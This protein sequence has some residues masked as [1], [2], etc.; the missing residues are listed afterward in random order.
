MPLYVPRPDGPLPEDLIED[1]GA[2]LAARYAA[3]EDELIREVARRA[4]RDLELQARAPGAPAG[5]GL[6]VAER[7]RQNRAL[8]ELAGHRAR[9]LRDLQTRAVQVVEGLRATGLAEQI[10]DIA[11]TEGE[12]AAAERLGMARNLPPTTVLSGTSTS[13]VTQ[14]TMDLSNRLETMNRRILRYPTDAYQRIIATTATNT[15]LGVTT[16]RVQQ[17]QAVAAF[18]SEGVTG[19]VDQAGRRWRIGSYAEMAGRTAVNRAYQEAGIARMQASGINLVTIVV[20]ASACEK[21][22]RWSNRVLSTDGT[23]GPIILPHATENRGVEVQVDGTLSDARASGWGHPNDRCQVVAYLPGL[24]IPADSTTYNPDAEK[25]RA[26]MRTLERRVRAAKRAEAVSGDDI[27][28]TDA[29]RRVRAAQ[30]EIRA[31]A[32]ATGEARSNYREQLHFTD[33]NR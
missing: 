2:A 18:L 17:Q 20:G 12:A 27:A 22:A 16:S 6:T 15:L 3:A 13:A 19:F 14:L 28:R 32:A 30:A 1:L 10:I 4:Y 29:R 7:R 33:G 9:T 23:V 5:N 11:A 26:R 8:A 31:H 25:A 21:C 24:S